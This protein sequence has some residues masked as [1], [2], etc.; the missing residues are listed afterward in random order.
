MKMTYY[1]SMT[2]RLFPFLFCSIIIVVPSFSLML[3]ILQK[4]PV[5]PEQTYYLLLLY[6]LHINGISAYP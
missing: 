1:E 6:V 3:R 2:P 5:F 4:E